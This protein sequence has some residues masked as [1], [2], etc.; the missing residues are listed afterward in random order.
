MLCIGVLKGKIS[1]VDLCTALMAFPPK[2]VM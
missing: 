1:P 2:D